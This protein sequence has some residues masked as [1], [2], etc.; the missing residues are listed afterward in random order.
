M[1][2][3]QLLLALDFGGTQLS[4]ALTTPDML[5]ESRWLARE[6]ELA[7]AG[8]D[9]QSDLQAL[10]S[11]S[12]R[13]LGGAAPAAVGVSFGGPV[14][15]L[16]GIV[17]R[18]PHVPGWENFPLRQ[19][20]EAEL[21]CPAALDNDANA[22]ALGEYRFGAGA[23]VASLL[24]V[25][26][27]TGV[28][29]GWILDGKI[30]RGA[31]GMAG[32]IGHTSLDPQGPL[33]L[34]GKRG[35][36]ERLASGPFLAQ[37]ARLALI[38][39]ASQG[40]EIRKLCGGAYDRI[41][42]ELL[43]RAAQAGDP[44]ATRLLARSAWAVGVG[45]GNAANLINPERAILGGGVTKAG[46]AWWEEARRA[47]RETMLAGVELPEGLARLGDDAPLWGAIALALEALPDE[48]G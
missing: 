37:D 41:T 16:A 10:L 13:L 20:L 21:Q 11:L 30:W 9:A 44:L 22:A 39:D 45:L 15:A 6:Q 42:G 24:Y 17:R 19:V 7:A 23:G 34:C 47:A 12:R 26:V 35:C 36:V 27:S 25:T 40:A 14:D 28:G 4:A 29:G 31:Q 38:A 18:S 1:P 2:A 33:C 43:S 8:I 32:E 46:P 5:A 3:S 48:R